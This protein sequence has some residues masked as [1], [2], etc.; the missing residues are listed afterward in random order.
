MSEKCRYCGAAVPA[1]TGAGRP[2][3]YCTIACRR[4]AQSM[5]QR[6]TRHLIALEE[7][8]MDLAHVVE[9]YERR[10]DG[11]KIT[12]RSGYV[13]PAERLADVRDDAARLRVRLRDLLDDVGLGL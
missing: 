11:S 12:S 3:D 2:A 4:A 1:S 8:E 7:E 10:G 5:R 9:H 6:I 13:T